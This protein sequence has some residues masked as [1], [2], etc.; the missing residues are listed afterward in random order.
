MRAFVRVFVCLQ[1]VLG[2]EW[3][4][5]GDESSLSSLVKPVTVVQTGS[6][7]KSPEKGF[8]RL[9]EQTASSPVNNLKLEVE[10]AN[11]CLTCRSP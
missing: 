11:S 3:N 9:E 7:S 10:L 6:S 1:H 2:S 4:L 5:N 8:Y